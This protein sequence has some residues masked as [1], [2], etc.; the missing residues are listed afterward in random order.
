VLSS[1]FSIPPPLAQ[2]LPSSLAANLSVTPNSGL[3]LNASPLDSVVYETGFVT[4]FDSSSSSSSTCNRHSNIT[5][6]T[7]TAAALELKGRNM[8]Q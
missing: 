5:A 2:L 7:P 1:T 3:V 6:T 4:V 8:W